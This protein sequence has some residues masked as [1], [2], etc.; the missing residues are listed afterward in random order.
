MAIASGHVHAL[1]GAIVFLATMVLATYPLVTI[2]ASEMLAN[3]LDTQCG[4][5][6]VI[7]SAALYLPFSSFTVGR[8]LGSFLGERCLKGDDRFIGAGVVLVPLSGGLV[9][10]AEVRHVDAELSGVK[11]SGLLDPFALL[12]LNVVEEIRVAGLGELLEAKGKPALLIKFDAVLSERVD[13]VPLL[14]HL[15][16]VVT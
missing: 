10:D 15:R 12:M 16:Q 7:F 5:V 6:R 3:I 1:L 14:L 11:L 8:I 13:I 2:R 9:I 4:K